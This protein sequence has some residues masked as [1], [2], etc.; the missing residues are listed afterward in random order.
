MAAVVVLVVPKIAARV[1][2]RGLAGWG[3]PRMV[4]QSS[5]Q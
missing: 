4:V 2:S 5:G 1:G 3:T